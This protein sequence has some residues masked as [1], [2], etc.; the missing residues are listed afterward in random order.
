[1]SNGFL[2]HF[3]KKMANTNI[4]EDLIIDMRNVAQNLHVFGENLLAVK[5]SFDK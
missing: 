5:S 1:M 4:L 3:K 2:I